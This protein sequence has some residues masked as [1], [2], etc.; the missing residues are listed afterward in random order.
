MNIWSFGCFFFF[1]Y[2]VPYTNTY[3]EKIIHPHFHLRTRWFCNRNP[4]NTWKYDRKF[5]RVFDFLRQLEKKKSRLTRDIQWLYKIK[6]WTKIQYNKMTDL[7]R[8][9]LKAYFLDEAIYYKREKTMRLNET[10]KNTFDNSLITILLLLT[11]YS[12]FNMLS[13]YI[14]WI[15]TFIYP[16]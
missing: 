10:R 13:L 4:S 11:P 2:V 1:V 6:L 3:W 9:Q 12:F 8:W 15:F 14:S 16:I 5:V 7:H